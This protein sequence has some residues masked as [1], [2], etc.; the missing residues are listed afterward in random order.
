MI[1][2]GWSG[3]N[4]K[5]CKGVM[6]VKGNIDCGE[7]V[8]RRRKRERVRAYSHASQPKLSQRTPGTRHAT[9]AFLTMLSKG[10][11]VCV[12]TQAR[13]T[14]LSTWCCTSRR[15][16][17]TCSVASESVA[18]LALTRPQPSRKSPSNREKPARTLQ[19]KPSSI[20]STHSSHHP[21]LLRPHLAPTLKPSSEPVDRRP[22]SSYNSSS[23]PKPP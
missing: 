14:E 4:W 19:A 16:S 1:A 13:K 11:V 23:Y 2:L 9:R 8:W 15:P 22:T 5:G 20:L 6:R 3:R 10:H 7:C 21:P 18:R 12:E 17:H